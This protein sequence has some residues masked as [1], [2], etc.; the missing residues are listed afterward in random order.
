MLNPIQTARAIARD[1][2]CEVTD[3]HFVYN[4]KRY[5]ARYLQTRLFSI[6]EFRDGLGFYMLPKH[7]Y[8]P[9]PNPPVQVNNVAN[10]GRTE[11]SDFDIDT[12]INE[13]TKRSQAS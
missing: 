6:S 7:A 11:I 4:R 9:V 2:E 3:I 1:Y 5:L 12:E 13:L 10:Q 8:P